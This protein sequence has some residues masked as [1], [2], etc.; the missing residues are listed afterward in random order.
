M[1][2]F[3]ILFNASKIS[4]FE[5]VT[6]QDLDNW[7]TE[8]S[9]EFHYASANFYSINTAKWIMQMTKHFHFMPYILIICFSNVNC[10]LLLRNNM[11]QTCHEN[12]K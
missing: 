10:Q 5:N 12:P 4:V 3:H 6:S 7:L 8:E 1:Q 9:L 2:K 11:L